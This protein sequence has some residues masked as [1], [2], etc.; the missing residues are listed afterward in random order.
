MFTP[1]VHSPAALQK[2]CLE[3]SSKAAFKILLDTIFPDSYREKSLEEI[4]VFDFQ[5]QMK[6]KEKLFRYNL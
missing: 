3:N 2:Q 6:L 1:N 4:L 5:D